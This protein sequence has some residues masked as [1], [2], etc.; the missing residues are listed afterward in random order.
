MHLPT[1][2]ISHQLI[3]RQPPSRKAINTSTMD[4]P[5]PDVT[6]HNQEDSPLKWPPGIKY[7]MTRLNRIVANQFKLQEFHEAKLAFERGDFEKCDQMSVEVCSNS[8]SEI[9]LGTC[10]TFLA[11]KELGRSVQERRRVFP[12]TP[13]RAVTRQFLLSLLCADF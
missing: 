12:A 6:H 7:P 13:G 8:Q 1:V 4:A 11:T 2:H 10:C 5:K 3:K 9:F